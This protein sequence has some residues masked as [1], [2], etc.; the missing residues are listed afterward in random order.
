MGAPPVVAPP[1]AGPA[2]PGATGPG[3]RLVVAIA[4]GALVGVLVSG[5]TAVLLWRNATREQLPDSCAA[6]GC[7]ELGTGASPG[8]ALTDQA[9]HPVDLASLRGKVVVLGFMD[10]VCVD[11]CPIVSDEFI[12]ADH[13]LGAQASQVEFV[14]VN[15]N[16]FHESTTAVRAFSMKH[17]LA[18]LPNWHFVTGTTSAL[19][20]VWDA[21][22]VAVIPN[23]SGDVVHTS[24]LYFIDAS[25]R[26]RLEASPVKS[27]ASI[28]TWAHG[29][30]DL[31]R[32][33]QAN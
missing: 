27:K 26:L 25:G 4:I 33:L 32:W 6:I 20:Q 2:E 22:H 11:I 21:Y 19:K 7:S 15:V 31:V 24:I 29:I 1:E 30:A 16:Q 5:G 17:H 8:F 18:D 12:R 3:R 10:P 9:G 28:V 23:P 14:S 13:L